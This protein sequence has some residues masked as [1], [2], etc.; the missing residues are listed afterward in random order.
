MTSTKY[1]VLARRYRPKTFSEVV[2]QE[3]VVTTLKN[4]LRFDKAAH[5]YLFS[6]SRGVGKTTLARLFA[7]A[8]NC[9]ERGADMEPCNR[10]PSCLE[11]GTGQSLDVIEID[12]ASNRGID[13]I[14]AIN[15]TALYSPSAGRY[16]IYI[17]DEVHMLTKEAFNALLKTLEEPPEKAKFFFATTEP[18][19]VL[20]TIISRC[21]RFD[22]GRIQLS[23]IIGK[24]EEIA[25]D[26][27]RAAEPEALHLIAAFSDG[28]L[29]DAE[30]LFDQ[31]LCFAHGAVTAASVRTTLGLLP[32]EHFF[33]LDQAF[34]EAR[35]AFAFELVETL[36]ASGK[37]LHH[38]YE[39][40]MEHVRNLASARL[41]GESGLSLPPDLKAKTLQSARL[42][43][44][45]QCLYLLEYLLQKESSLQKSACQRVALE[46][47]LLHYIQS[48]NRIPVEVLVR[49][50]SEMEESLKLQGTSSPP[51]SESPKIEPLPE[52]Y[53]DRSKSVKNPKE[54]A[55]IFDSGTRDVLIDTARSEEQKYAAKLTPADSHFLSGSS[56][57]KPALE[58]TIK[59]SPPPKIENPIPE[60]AKPTP[61]LASKT[62]IETPFP[63]PELK[64]PSEPA[65]QPP[66]PISLKPTPFNPFKQAEKKPEPAEPEQAKPKPAPAKEAVKE[67]IPLSSQS[68]YDTL[69]RFATV[70]LEGTLKLT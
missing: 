35:A 30:S 61:E 70:E 18:H 26:L 47:I 27:G 16:K 49:R 34:S 60:I 59:T 39:Q 23:Q 51:V 3:S 1:Q 67:P 38:F 2:G 12:G 43:A 66:R 50:L 58:P 7:K 33:A 36:F 40:L 45:S 21:Q 25:S 22:L 11:I 32:Q 24:L 46:S 9:Q 10:C 5:A 8:L 56:I 29:R 57:T 62:K 15:E 4:A 55:Q 48:K 64:P 19:K 52:I 28:S 41:L 44:P 6:G 13:D 63:L 14:R 37:D 54:A 65:P 68:R 20:P 53:C 69:M 17:I 31:I 42:Y